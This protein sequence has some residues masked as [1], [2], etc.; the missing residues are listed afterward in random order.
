[1]TGS[2]LFKFG[3]QLVQCVAHLFQVIN[4]GGVQAVSKTSM[5]AFVLAIRQDNKVVWA[6]IQRVAVAMMDMFGLCQRPSD[7]RSHNQPVLQTPRPVDGDVAIPSFDAA[8]SAGSAAI[9]RIVKCFWGQS[10]PHHVQIAQ[11]PQACAESGS[12]F[13]LSMTIRNVALGGQRSAI[14]PADARVCS[15]HRV[16]GFQHFPDGQSLFVHGAPTR[17][18]MTMLGTTRRAAIGGVANKSVI[19]H[20]QRIA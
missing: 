14:C 10:D 1:M 19:L 3:D 12:L 7:D 13:W 2:R 9:M 11:R 8:A 5:E 17:R 4:R 18:S 6:V 15:N 16:I 20:G